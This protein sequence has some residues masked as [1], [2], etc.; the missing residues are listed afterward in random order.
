MFLLILIKKY[1]I[2]CRDV[3]RSKHILNF[4]ISFL[5]SNIAIKFYL[6]FLFY[7]FYYAILIH[8]DNC[9]AFQIIVWCCSLSICHFQRLLSVVGPIERW[10]FWFCIPCL[11]ISRS[12]LHMWKALKTMVTFFILVCLLSRD[13]YLKV[14]LLL[15]NNKLLRICVGSSCLACAQSTWV[16][17]P[18]FCL[19]VCRRLQWWS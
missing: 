2:L 9:N 13:S 5:N 1:A 7:T 14:A 18:L 19:N 15:N 4:W 3:R 16:S 12:L 11:C 6:S 10:N 8:N 17:L